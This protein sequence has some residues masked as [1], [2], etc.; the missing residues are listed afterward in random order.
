MPEMIGLYQ[1]YADH[2][3]KFEV[4]AIHDQSVKS[5][6]ELDQKLPKIK[7][8]FW[9]GKDLP[10]PILLDATG[11]TVKLYGIHAF[12]TNLL[13]DPAGKLVGEVSAEELVAKLPP[14]PAAKVWARHRDVQKKVMWSFVGND[15]TPAR[16]AET[17]KE[18]TGC[19]VQVDEAALKACGLAP[20]DPLPGVMVGYAVTLRSIEELFLAPQGLGI[21]PAADGKK[22]LITKRPAAAEPPSY[23]QK[24]RAKELTVRLDRGPTEEEQK[25]AKPLEIKDQRL[26]DAF[27]LC[28]GSS[29]CRSR[30]T[31]KRCGPAR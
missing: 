24:A 9:Q 15:R 17:L 7:R 4:I 31:R 27:K 23:L 28:S 6:A 1:D 12:P 30:S 2:R 22:L 8:Q 11:A 19:T 18:L 29:T 3:D 26:M 13:I 25:T 20:G 14:L 10:F 21:V 5:F 16:M